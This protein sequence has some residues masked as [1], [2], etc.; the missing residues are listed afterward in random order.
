[1][2]ETAFTVMC[3]VNNPLTGPNGAT[4]T[5]GSQ[6]GANEVSLSLL[7]TGMKNYAA[8]IKRK[9][10]I[11]VDS[12]PGA[13]AAG[14]LGAAL[15][16]FL[17]ARLRS[18]I[19]TVL[20]L[21]HFDDLLKDVDLV[22]TGEGRIDWQS[23]CGKVLDGIGR[24]C[25]KAGIPAVAIVGGMGRGAEEIYSHGISSILPTINADMDIAEAMHR[26]AELYE[27]AADRM[28]R[29]LKVG[30]SMRKEN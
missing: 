4:Y 11:D 6:K 27:N 20:D 28:F 13:G 19:E 5:F 29:L 23:A 16:V 26:S 12:M 1:M 10:S 17:N 14:G 9:F 2:K 21:I 7:E 8:L 15:M 22:V 30:I 18:G 24:R 25:Q 3:D